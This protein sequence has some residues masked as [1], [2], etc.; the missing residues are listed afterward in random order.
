[1]EI[2]YSAFGE[3]EKSD[4]TEEVDKVL[5][6]LDIPSKY[7]FDETI[8]PKLEFRITREELNRFVKWDSVKG[9]YEINLDSSNDP[10][11]RLLYAVLWKNRD[12]KKINH[13]IQGIMNSEDGDKDDGLVFYQFGKFLSSSTEPIIDQHV[14]RAFGIYK[15]RD[16]QKHLDYYVSLNTLSRTDKPIIAS[17]KN[18]LENGLK[19]SLR[20][21]N[22]YRYKVDKILYGLGKYAKD[23]HRQTKS[24]RSKA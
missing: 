1:M 18:W 4:T 19:Q 22:E 8:Y 3:L 14:I 20:Q 24:S 15:S 16:N 7:H 5:S 23:H 9:S 13:V 21:Q 17:Y 2:I 6:K 11:A 10:L 12:L